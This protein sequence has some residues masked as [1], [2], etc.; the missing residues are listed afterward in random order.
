MTGDK[1]VAVIIIAVSMRIG[2]LNGYSMNSFFNIHS[3]LRKGLEDSFKTNQI[4]IIHFRSYD[5]RRMKRR[6][7]GLHSKK[8]KKDGKLFYHYFYSQSQ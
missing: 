6:L 2:M 4:G 5:M 8:L 3:L 7:I 1:Y